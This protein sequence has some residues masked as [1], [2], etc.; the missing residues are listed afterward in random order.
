MI[1]CLSAWHPI[2]ARDGCL[3]YFPH[4]IQEKVA[5]TVDLSYKVCQFRLPFLPFSLFIFRKDW[6]PTRNSV[7]VTNRVSVRGNISII[8]IFSVDT[9]NSYTSLWRKKILEIHRGEKV[10]ILISL[11]DPFYVMAKHFSIMHKTR[12]VFTFICSLVKFEFPFYGWKWWEK[13]EKFTERT[14][15]A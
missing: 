15:K 2:D 5:F 11:L 3:K 14:W 12:C 8:N 4:V 7:Q 9:R 1:A 6:A 13:N 10:Y